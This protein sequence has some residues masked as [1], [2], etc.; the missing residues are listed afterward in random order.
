MQEIVKRIQKV[1]DEKVRP[2]LGEH[3]GDIEIV[4]YSDGILKVRLLGQCCNCPSANLTMESVV[5]AEI[6][7]AVKE[8]QDVVL[9]TGVSD[10]LLNMASQILKQR[11]ETK[12][13]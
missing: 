7:D 13:V 8:V 2:A 4:E 6:K 12:E 11:R 5:S 9:I 10:E 1:I 3:Q